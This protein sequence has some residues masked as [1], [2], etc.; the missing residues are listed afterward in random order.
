MRAEAG[1]L[2]ERAA[3]RHL[4]RRGLA[5]EVYS[6]EPLGGGV[7]GSVL[8]AET[9]RGPLIVKQPLGRLAV[10]AD[11]RASTARVVSEAAA[12]RIAEKTLG[13]KVP[14]LLDLDE[15]EC[16]LVT[17]VAATGGRTW[18][19]QLMDGRGD[20]ATAVAAATLLAE[21]HRGTR[22]VT[23]PVLESR[24]HFV[25]LRIDSYFRASTVRVPTLAR[26]L[27]A[28]VEVALGQPRCVVH[29][30][31][32]PKNLLVDPAR[33]HELTAVDWE[34]AH[35]GVPEFDLAFLLSHLLLKT[36][37]GRVDG[38]A[39]A[40][41]ALDAYRA[42]EGLGSDE[43]ATAT[44][45]GALLIARVVGWSPVE[46]LSPRAGEATVA[47]GGKLLRRELELAEAMEIPACPG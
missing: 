39:L 34:V 44:L 8:R 10:A 12:L 30:D 14:A 32:S 37:A 28:A 33:P 19:T 24:Q 17:S 40:R 35:L 2:D 43:G 13:S 36:I 46:Y 25:S 45:L 21:L 4:L 23:D 16:V 42:A 1:T 18:K 3:A 20:P 5:R 31:F 9:D 38:A 7:S 15:E 29:G 22:H 26:A 6:V 47:L 27:D 41:D 11:W